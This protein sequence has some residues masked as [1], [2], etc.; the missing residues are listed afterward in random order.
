LVDS[1]PGALNLEDGNHH[2]I[3]WTRD[4]NGRMTVTVDGT[5]LIDVTDRGFRD[6]FDGI[7]MVNFE[8][9]FAVRAVEVNG[10]AQ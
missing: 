8:G 1:V 4:R 2:F 10:V 7:T 9:D 6:P 5:K 3:E